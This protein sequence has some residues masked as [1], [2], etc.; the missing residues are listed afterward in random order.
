M[1]ICL[2][3]TKLKCGAR[4]QGSVNICPYFIPKSRSSSHICCN[5]TVQWLQYSP[6]AIFKCI[7][8]RR[9]LKQWILLQCI[10]V[11]ATEQCDDCN[12]NMITKW[13][14]TVYLLCNSVQ[15]LV[16]TI[17]WYKQIYQSYNERMKYRYLN[18][19][20]SGCCRLLEKTISSSWSIMCVGSDASHSTP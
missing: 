18:G 19:A 10:S 5:R 13:K 9:T 12:N 20:T 7:Y 2:A 3:N 11:I 1:Q 8:C 16:F 14:G 17:N 4:E 15:L 6:N